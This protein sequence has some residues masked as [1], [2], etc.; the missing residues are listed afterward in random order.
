MHGALLVQWYGVVDAGS[1]ASPSCCDQVPSLVVAL[2]SGVYW[3]KTEE[4]VVAL[5]E[6]AAEH[7]SDLTWRA[8][9]GF[10]GLNVSYRPWRILRINGGLCYLT[11]TRGGQLINLDHLESSSDEVTHRSL[12][13]SACGGVGSQVSIDFLAMEHTHRDLVIQSLTRLGYRGNYHFWD[14]RGGEYEYPGRRRSFDDD[15]H[16]VRYLIL[17]QVL[18]VGVFVKLGHAKDGFYER[19]GGRRLLLCSGRS[20]GYLFRERHGLL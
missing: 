2:D 12:S 10:I 19:M 9:S 18:D 6:Y 11:D 3:V 4:I 20:Q 1:A 8:G 16:F 7:L 5:P 15:E 13:A 17:H 14:V